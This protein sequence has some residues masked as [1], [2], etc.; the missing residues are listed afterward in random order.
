MLE[1]RLQADKDWNKAHGHL[2]IS[3]GAFYMDY[4]NPIDGSVK[5]VAFRDPDYPFV[6]GKRIAN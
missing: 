2:I 5:L 4:Y 1:A 6:A 3:D